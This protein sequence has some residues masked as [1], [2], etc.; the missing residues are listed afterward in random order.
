MPKTKSQRQLPEGVQQGTYAIRA[1]ASDD[2]STTLEIDIREFIGWWD[3]EQ[4]N[5]VRQVRAAKPD[6]IVLSISSLGGFVADALAIHDFLR[7]YPAHVVA[8]ISG[9]TASAATMIAMAGDEVRMSDNALFLVHHASNVLLAWGKA[10]DIEQ[11]ADQATRELRKVNGRIINLYAKK[12]DLSE[13]QLDE[14]LT[15]EEWLTP[16]EALGYGFIDEI[17]EPAPSSTETATA[18]A[19][20][21]AA[22]FAAIGLPPL[23]EHT[24]PTA[25]AMP[26]TKK[27]STAN[28][29]APENAKPQDAPEQQPEARQQP[30]ERD[31]YEEMRA[32]MAVL[33]AQNAKLAEERR[34]SSLAALRSTLTGRVPSA[35][36]EKVVTAADKASKGEEVDVVAVLTEAAGALPEMVAT[37]RIDTGTPDSEGAAVRAKAALKM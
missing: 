17:Y 36:V 12:T 14:I 13:E 9:M 33:K 5:F 24:K 20:Q 2:G 18:H 22:I 8:D 37:G 3:T 7:A 16:A 21:H 34:Q 1:A 28:A 30:D 6:R 23:P 19:A 15:A 10:E 26:Q 29:P 31:K 25:T 27:E 35:A 4:S 32:E 11:A